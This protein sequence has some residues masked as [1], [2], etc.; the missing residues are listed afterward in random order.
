MVGYCAVGGCT[1]RVT[2]G[3]TIETSITLHTFPKQYVEGL[4]GSKTKDFVAR[5]KSTICSDHFTIESFKNYNEV[6]LKKEMGMIRARYGQKQLFFLTTDAVPSI[7]PRMLEKRKAR[8]SAGAR[9]RKQRTSLKEQREI[10][11]DLITEGTH[12]YVELLFLYTTRPNKTKKTQQHYKPSS[13]TIH[14]HPYNLDIY[15]MMTSL[16]ISSRALKW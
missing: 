12:Y 9:K 5:A 15:L 16:F 2:V 3:T 7:T 10:L 6:K 1:N 13:L 14:N 8:L 11:I 4:C